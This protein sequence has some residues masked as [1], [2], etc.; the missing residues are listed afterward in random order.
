MEDTLKQFKHLGFEYQSFQ[1]GC[2]E[3]TAEQFRQWQ[4]DK[5]NSTDDEI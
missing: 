2:E 1:M 4:I 5:M 3:I